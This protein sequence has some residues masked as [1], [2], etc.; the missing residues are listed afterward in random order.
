TIRIAV[1]FENSSPGAE[2][3]PAS[4]RVY[5]Y[6]MQHVYRFFEGEITKE[7]LD[8]AAEEVILLGRD[9]YKA[10]DEATGLKTGEERQKQIVRRAIAMDYPETKVQK[11]FN[12]T[13]YTFKYEALG[14]YLIIEFPMD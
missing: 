7:E 13:K 9:N 3:L 4:K 6:A 2:N 11:K 1:K 10:R 12:G 8:Q 5:E 14:G